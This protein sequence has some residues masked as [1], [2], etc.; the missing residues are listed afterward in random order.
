[1]K[2]P[3]ALTFFLILAITKPM[4]A[5]S[6]METYEVSDSLQKLPLKMQEVKSTQHQNPT[7]ENKK[8]V[9]KKEAI[10]RLDWQQ[11]IRRKQ[12]SKIPLQRMIQHRY[13]PMYNRN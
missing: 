1:M 12:L 10:T 4:H 11:K 5:L 13:R 2:N 6:L 9:R 7:L 3:I 8:P